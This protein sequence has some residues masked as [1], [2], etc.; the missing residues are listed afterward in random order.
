MNAGPWLAAAAV[1]GFFGFEMYAA[2]RNS[3]RIEPT[4]IF[5]QFAGA[6]RGN[7]LCGAAGDEQLAKFSNNYAWTRKRATDA[8]AEQ[9]PDKSA[10]QIDAMIAAQQ[11]AV[12]MEVDALVDEK[13]CK[14]IEAWKL[15]KR[16]DNMSRLNLPK[17]L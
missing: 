2:S 7:T 14:D 17:I 6:S 4:H 3:Y 15:V 12:Y 9:F 5:G 1:V 13:S 11:D 16:F 8:L 10:D